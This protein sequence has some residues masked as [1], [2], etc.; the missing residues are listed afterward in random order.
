MK[1]INNLITCLFFLS[2]YFLWGQSLTISGKVFSNSGAEP[3][4]EVILYSGDTALKSSLT[5]LDGSF[6]IKA[7]PGTYRVVIR[8]LASEFYSQ[9]ISPKSDMDLG[10][11]IIDN[12]QVLEEVTLV[13]KK[14]VITQKVDRT[15]FNV[16][17]TPASSSGTAID[18]LK[19][20]PK[21]QVKQDDISIIGKGGLQ[22]M[23]D[24]RPL[25]LS[26]K[27]L[28]KYL[29]SISAYDIKNIEVITTPPAK[30][31]AEGN[32]GILNIVLKK[33]R[34]NSWSDSFGTEYKQGYYPGFSTRNTFS[35]NKGKLSLAN[36]TRMGHDKWLNCLKS[37]IAYPDVFWDGQNTMVNKNKNISNRLGLDYRLTPSTTFGFVH[38]YSKGKYDMDISDLVK[39]SEKASGVALNTITSESSS[40]ENNSRHSINLHL[41]HDID[42]L[43]QQLSVD[44]DYLNNKNYQNQILESH[45]HSNGALS[46]KNNTTDRNSDNLSIKADYTLPLSFATYNFGG[47]LS[48]SVV[49][50]VVNFVNLS[51]SVVSTEFDDFKYIE[52]IQALY[53]SLSKEFSSKFQ[54]KAGLRAENTLT[55][56]VSN[57]SGQKN[58]DNYLEFFPSLYLNYIPF[59]NHTFNLNYSRRLQRPYFWRLNP[60][61]HYINANVYQ[62]GNPYLKPDIYNN[63]ELTHSF[64]SLLNT[65]LSYSKVSNSSSQI[66]D[67]DVSNML[68]RLLFENYLNGNIY[69]LS[70][71]LSYPILSWWDSTTTLN[72]TVSNYHY[73]DSKYERLGQLKKYSPSFYL[74]ST[75]YFKL[76]K[77]GNHKAQL[78][79]YYT[80]ATDEAEKKISSFSLCN[81]S[82]VSMFLDRSLSVSLSI[83]DLF[84]ST[85]NISVEANSSSTNQLYTN[86]HSNRSFTLSLSWRFG[87]KSINTKSHT[88]GNEQEQ[89]RM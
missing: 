62:Q 73:T 37:E 84:D 81:L 74:N 36:N 2:S 76:D 87:N 3:N 41:I 71:T 8:Q 56:G 54:T 89:S 19:I 33:A 13:S 9:N 18:M 14:D 48:H 68:Q 22:V 42:T 52:D 6:S 32:S 26:G 46:S 88:T 16:E 34:A 63:I 70:Q 83:N 30:Y 65:S 40:A 80:S 29:E 53:F 60:A 23:I 12:T 45:S 5:L 50:N 51:S 4:L 15:V 43:G 21:V 31:E 75:H 77:D 49:N 7:T 47:K 17:N 59:E 28:S 39:T 85:K 10:I 79:W 38:F 35:L 78:Y 66:L 61:K 20:T 24:G 44:L 11:I 1:T 67:V 55:Q 69:S 58:T 72:Y 25:S 64:K 86:T 82:F 57:V 27:E